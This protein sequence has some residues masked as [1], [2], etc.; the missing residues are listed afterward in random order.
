MDYLFILKKIV[1]VLLLPPLLPLWMTAF[2]LTV[3]RRRPR[4]GRRVAWLGVLISLV[5]CTPMTVR[6]IAKPLEI[7]PVVSADAMRQTQAI[8]IL[9]GGQRRAPEYEA[10]SV[11]NRLSLER[12]QYGSRLAK[13]SNLPILVTGGGPTDYTPEAVLM[14]QVLKDDF[15]IEAK[16]VEDRS[17][18]TYDNARYSA[19]ILRNAGISR[20]TLVT[21][22][23]HMRRSVNEFEA[24]GIEVV[25][26]PTV[27]MSIEPREEV[28]D[29]IPSISTAYSGWYALHEWI[30][31]V[32]QKLR[33]APK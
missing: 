17:L 21:H 1:S 25:P 32:A 20:V 19:A 13:Q 4:L 14:A 2:G 6:M 9:A 28:F 3:I 30:G 12:I 24:Q 18:D 10:G 33:M 23:L 11:P 27:F 16:W 29:Y 22:A 26:A 5:L 15:G 7:Y 8:V 31:L